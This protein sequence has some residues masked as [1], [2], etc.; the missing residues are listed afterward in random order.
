MQY[1]CWASIDSVHV[2]PITD[3]DVHITSLTVSLLVFSILTF[4]TGFL[5]GTLL[6]KIIMKKDKV[7]PVPVP[8]SVPLHEEI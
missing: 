4:L 1:E 6:V 5:L 2:F 8:G 3:V 7:V